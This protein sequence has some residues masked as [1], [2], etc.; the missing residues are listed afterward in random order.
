MILLIELSVLGMSLIL[1]GYF[2]ALMDLSSEGQEQIFFLGRRVKAKADTWE[3]K[4][5]QIIVNTPAK[6]HTVFTSY[7]LR[8]WWYLGLMRLPRDEKFPFS[9]TILVWLTDDW[10]L[11]KALFLFC[12]DTCI[13]VPLHTQLGWYALLGYLVFPFI[14]FI[15]FELKYKEKL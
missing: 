2:N 14:R 10:H 15:S 8:P 9:S 11:F 6:K 3:D 5:N 12:I 7:N 1:A 4:W 13:V